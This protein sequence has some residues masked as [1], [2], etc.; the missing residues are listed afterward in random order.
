MAVNDRSLALARRGLIANP[1]RDDFECLATNEVWRG[2]P[3]KLL[4]DSAELANYNRN[5]VNWKT[6]E[7]VY[8]E[9][10]LSPMIHDTAAD[11]ITWRR[12]L[13]ENFYPRVRHEDRLRTKRQPRRL[14]SFFASASP[15]R[16][17]WIRRATGFCHAWEAG[18]ANPTGFELLYE[19]ALRSVGVAARLDT[20]NRTEFWNGQ[21][22]LPAP[23]SLMET[24]NEFS[25]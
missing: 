22:W 12:E 25:K 1:W 8:R 16:Q 24:A 20:S 14:C 6:P 9:Y 15:L 2:K 5:L 11:D 10:V 17:E 18:I 7:P 19:A 4:L 21:N 23:R 3:L 13:W